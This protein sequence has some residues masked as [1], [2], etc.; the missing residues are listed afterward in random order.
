MSQTKTLLS[1]IAGTTNATVGTLSDQWNGATLSIAT[2]AGTAIATVTIYAQSNILKKVFED[3]VTLAGTDGTTLTFPST[4]ASVA[5]TDA[6]QTFVGG[7]T[8]PAFAQTVQTVAVST[9][10]SV[11]LASGNTVVLG[12]A[13]TPGALTAA[14][15][16]T[17]TNPTVGSTTSLTFIQFST[18]VAVSFTATG[19]T[20]YEPGKTAG[21]ASGSPVLLAADM[22]LSCIYNAQITWLSATT[23]LV[24]LLKS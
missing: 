9:T 4:S 23:A 16:V 21:V 24:E 2:T 5:R 18:S 10:P 8:A 13:G 7:Q 22:T 15:N 17:F 14:S 20:F 1:A 12:T 6:A 19:Y 3:T 11:N